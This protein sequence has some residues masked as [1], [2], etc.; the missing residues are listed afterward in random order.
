MQ[1]TQ[2]NWTVLAVAAIAVTLYLQV[3]NH[4]MQRTLHTCES[5]FDNFKQGLNYGSRLDR[6]KTT[7]PRSYW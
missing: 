6:Y 5:N 4:S 7:P 3:K 2:H 1:R